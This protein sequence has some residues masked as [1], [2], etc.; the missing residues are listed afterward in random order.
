MRRA[1]VVLPAAGLADDA[2]GLAGHHLE[3]DPV[4]GLH[5]ADVAAHDHA[6]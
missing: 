6:A 1:V 4:H 3:V 2:E 5:R